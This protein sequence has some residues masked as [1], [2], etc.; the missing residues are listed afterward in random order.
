MIRAQRWGNRKG[1]E[2]AGR[3]IFVS[4]TLVGI[5]CRTGRVTCLAI[6]VD[7]QD[8]APVPLIKMASRRFE[9]QSRKAYV[10]AQE[11][12]RKENQ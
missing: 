7:F 2:S 5:A 6:A 4:G 3:R 8:R 9:S 10:D 1:R 12:K 11:V